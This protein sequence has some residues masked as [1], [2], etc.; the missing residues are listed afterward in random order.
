MSSSG[1]NCET[2]M[3]WPSVMLR[4]T[5]FKKKRKVSMSRCY[6]QL[7]HKSKK[8][9]LRRSY[10]IPALDFAYTRI[11]NTC[12]LTSNYCFAR[13]SILSSRSLTSSLSAPESSSGSSSTSGNF[14]ALFAVDFVC[15]LSRSIFQSYSADSF[16][17]SRSK[18]SMRDFCMRT[19]SS[20]YCLRVSLW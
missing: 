15:S 16:A 10:L 19:F 5:P 11:S 6:P 4:K 14:S 1:L 18:S 2:F 20:T 12:K 13:F 7:K 3:C 8:N 9:S 17:E